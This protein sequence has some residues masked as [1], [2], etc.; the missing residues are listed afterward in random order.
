MG[1]V[2]LVAAMARL[3]AP[4]LEFAKVLAGES[5]GT[6]SAIDVYGQRRLVY[7]RN[8]EMVKYLVEGLNRSKRG[9]RAFREDYEAGVP[10]RRYVPYT[11]RVHT[12]S[13][14]Y[15]VHCHIS[16]QDICMSIP[17]EEPI[18]D[19]PNRRFAFAEP[20][21]A[22][23]IEILEFLHSDYDDLE[24]EEGKYARLFVE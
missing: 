9:G 6:I 8:D 3:W 19:E 17:F 20:I 11:L 24:H 22:K 2:L 7:C 18:E 10:P 21:P 23:M 14:S 4:R 13:G 15:S 5:F 1:V 16:K 12:S